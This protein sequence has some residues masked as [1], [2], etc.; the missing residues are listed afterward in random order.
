MAACDDFGLLSASL[1][2]RF[3]HD[4]EQD[5]VYV[6]APDGTE[7]QLP[8]PDLRECLDWIRGGSAEDLESPYARVMDASR[9]RLLAAEQRARTEKEAAEGALSALLSLVHSE[10]RLAIESDGRFRTLSLADRTLERSRNAAHHDPALARELAEIG[11]WVS[12]ALNPQS[13]GGSRV[14]NVQALAA[15][16][17]GH[18]LR[19]VGDIRGTRAAFRQARELLELGDEDS[20]EALEVYDLETILRRDLRDFEGALAL[21]ERVIEGYSSCDQHEAAAQALQKR[22][23]ILYHMDDSA[24]AIEVLTKASEQAL[25]TDSGMLRLTVQHSLALALARAGRIDEAAEVFASTEGLYR[26][27]SS[28]N[29]DACRLWAQGLIELEGG[30]PSDVVDPL[31]RARGIF[32]SH[33]YVLDAAIVSLDLAAALAGLGRF[34]EVRELA[35]ATYAFMESR[36]VHP[37]ALAALAIF[38]QAAARE[39]VTREL[40]HDVA[41]RLVEA[42][43]R[44]P[45]V[46]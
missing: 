29:V 26:Q 20:F 25:R 43:S 10:R 14:R 35:A 33:G 38:Q 45:S 2:S 39:R 30:N 24:G 3:I 17:R 18:A 4:R 15:A 21:N 31:T 7:V 40:L 11:C 13:Y 44:R 9:E 32:E 6:T 12:E 22:S 1:G 19:I 41:K 8:G 46:S 42:A 36:E 16:T 37:D 5:V 28:P 27:F 23:S 34:A